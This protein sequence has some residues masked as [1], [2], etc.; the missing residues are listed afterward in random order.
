MLL[1]GNTPDGTG[2]RIE[3]DDD[4]GFRTDSRISAEFLEAGTYTIEATTYSAYFDHSPQRAT[5]D[6]T[7][8][9]A[10]DYTPRVPQHPKRLEVEVGSRFSH[11]WLHEP[12]S[13]RVRLWRP[14]PIPP[15]LDAT[16]SVGYLDGEHVSGS[17]RVRLEATAT[18]PREHTLDFVYDNG[19]HTAIKR[20][21][22]DAT[23]AAGQVTLPLGCVTPVGAKQKERYSYL[24]PAP[25][26]HEDAIECTRDGGSAGPW[27]FT[28]RRVVESR[29]YV[30]KTDTRMAR[31][32]ATP[33]L[34]GGESLLLP[35]VVR[36]GPRPSMAP[37]PAGDIGGF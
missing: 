22:I 26:G 13:A 33:R 37:R 29:Q 19:G 5:G 35:S 28:C 12:D 7:L 23:C 16:V 1:N 31:S 15:G 6:Y 24:R 11:T 36:C 25:S 4:S 27:L 21:V 8:I 3:A 2:A 32:R 34:C 20:T 9:V 14:H 18:I 10:V 30:S 17:R